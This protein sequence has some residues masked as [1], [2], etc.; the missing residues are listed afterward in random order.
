MRSFIRST[1]YFQQLQWKLTVSYTLTTVLALLLVECIIGV[2]I[3]NLVET[4]APHYLVNVVS[5]KGHDLTPYFDA[6][7][8]DHAKLRAQ[9]ATVK[10]SLATL[11]VD[12]QGYVAIVLLMHIL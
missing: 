9:L 7:P 6:A 5:Q 1:R 2:F 11:F 3:L 8:V 10:S 4:S 12:Y